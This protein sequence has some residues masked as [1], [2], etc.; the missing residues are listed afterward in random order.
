MERPRLDD[1]EQLHLNRRV[2]IADFVQEDAAESRARLQ[3]P[4]LVL[5]RAGK[6]AAPVS[7]QFRFHQGAR[8]SAAMLIGWNNPDGSLLE[9]HALL[10]EGHE[11]G[12]RDGAR[13][14]LLPRAGGA[15]D[16]RGEV[17]HALEQH[18]P[19]AAYVVGED[20]LPDRR[21]QTRRRD[22]TPDDVLENVVER[23]DDLVVAGEGVPGVI[24]GGQFHAG[25]ME[26]VVPFP[27]ELRIEGPPAGGAGRG[28]V[29]DPVVVALE[30]PVEERV[31]VKLELLPRAAGLASDAPGAGRA[32]AEAA[33]NL[34]RVG[35]RPVWVG[36][37]QAPHRPFFDEVRPQ[38][39]AFVLEEFGRN[40]LE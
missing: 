29:V 10:V 27:Q 34:H 19:V 2:E 30:Q 3:P 7:E 26:V 20:G 36:D 14:K 8:Q 25:D 9:R 40:G 12:E 24:P 22:R 18:P 39:L 17:A 6:G 13:D 33:R 37:L 31:F 35:A 4:A 32:W 38:R 11:P 5:D 1:A 16:Q 15:G 21:A 23:A 28:G